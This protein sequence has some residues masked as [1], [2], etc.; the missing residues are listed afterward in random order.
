[1]LSQQRCDAGGGGG[2]WVVGDA[3]GRCHEFLMVFLVAA[4]QAEGRLLLDEVASMQRL[5]FVALTMRPAHARGCTRTCRAATRPNPGQR[6]R[7]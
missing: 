7:L 3:G 1:M 2:A 5:P 6:S 4:G